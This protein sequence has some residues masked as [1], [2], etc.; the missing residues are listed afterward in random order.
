MVCIEIA[1]DACSEGSSDEENCTR[2]NPVG[3]QL[4][5]QSKPANEDD[6]PRKIEDMLTID[7]ECYELDLNHGRIGKIEDLEPLVNIER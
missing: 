6:A 5:S 2:S 1:V 4:S 3:P 7:P